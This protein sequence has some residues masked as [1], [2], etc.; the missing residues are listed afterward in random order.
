MKFNPPLQQG[1]L[2]K[3]YRRFLTDIET[4]TGETMTIHCPNTGSMLNCLLPESDLWYEAS[5]Y[6]HRKTKGTW[7]IAT[8]PF[9]RLAN[10]NTHLA[11]RLIEEA[12]ENGTI[13]L[14]LPYNKLQR[15]VKYGNENSRIDIRLTHLTPDSESFTYIEV[16]SVTLGFKDSDIAAF[17]DAVTTRG[18]KHLRE[19]TELAKNGTNA[20]LIYCVNLEGI[21]GVRPADEIDAEYGKALRVAAKNGVKILAFATSITPNEIKITHEIPVLL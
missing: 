9:V 18:T 4:T 10:V 1:K 2:I 11:N 17:P 12:L 5:Q 20:V 8:T 7:V 14:G 21:T 6:P 16:K 15:E 3:R 13:N 19:L